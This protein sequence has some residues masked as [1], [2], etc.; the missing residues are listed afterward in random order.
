[1]LFPLDMTV[2]W[3]IFLQDNNRFNSAKQMHFSRRSLL[4]AAYLGTTSFLIPNVTLAKIELHSGTISTLSDG[5]ITLP[6]KLTFDAMPKKQLDAIIREFDLSRNLLDRECN[7]TLFE[8]SYQKVLF[9]AG[10][11]TSFLDG[12]GKLIDS[13]DAVNLYPDDITDIIFTH[14]HPD[15]IWG[16]FDDFDDLTFPN[17][18]YYIGQNEWD[19]WLNPETVKN[20]SEDRIATVQ[21]R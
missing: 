2:V 6:S 21:Y 18:S 4:K 7:V 11:G 12:S 17:A 9:D 20:V 19:F 8:N 1:M 14:A 13:L 15:H 3:V 10:A 5:S 16:I